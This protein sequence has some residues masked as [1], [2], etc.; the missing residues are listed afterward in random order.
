V[1][2]NFFYGTNVIAVKQIAPHHIQALGIS[3]S[4]IFFTAILLTMFPL[5]N[6][7]KE[8]IE[9]KDYFRLINN[10]NENEGNNY[11]LL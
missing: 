9:K 5:F 1:A 4:R 7:K 3:F 11:L 10:Y 8:R 6:G 2:A